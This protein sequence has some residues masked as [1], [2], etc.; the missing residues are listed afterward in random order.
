MSKHQFSMP[1]YV[2][3]DINGDE[4]L[5]G[6]T[7]LPMLINLRETTFVVFYAEDDDAKPTATLVIR[8]RQLV[9]R[10]GE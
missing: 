9:A 1:L 7:D 4:Y 3:K 6:S 10:G 5:I 2:K 8:P